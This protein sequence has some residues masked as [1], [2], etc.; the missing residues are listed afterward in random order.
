M[1]KLISCDPIGQREVKSQNVRTPDIEKLRHSFILRQLVVER[2]RC[3]LD[4]VTF[5]DAPYSLIEKFLTVPPHHKDQES[6]D[7]YVK[8]ESLEIMAAFKKYEEA[9]PSYME[10][11]KAL[12]PYK[13]HRW[14]LYSATSA[15]VLITIEV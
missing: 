8:S 12:T 14:H 1:A 3:L 5:N 6:I 7:R 2:I 10:D 4:D 15:G 13:G 11:L 9:H